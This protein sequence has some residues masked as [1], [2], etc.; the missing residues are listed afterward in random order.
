[1]LMSNIITSH[2]QSLLF[3]LII[4]SSSSTYLLHFGYSH[5]CFCFFSL[6]FLIYFFLATNFVCFYF[7]AANIEF[8]YKAHRFSSL[9]HSICVRC[10]F[11]VGSRYAIGCIIVSAYEDR[12]RRMESRSNHVQ[13]TRY[14]HDKTNQ[15][16]TE[17]DYARVKSVLLGDCLQELNKC[18]AWIAVIEWWKT[19]QWKKKL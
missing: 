6:I 15:I 9:L 18:Q 11:F 3:I 2:S 19:A 17:I 7:S 10:W 1:M 14:T 16:W 13:Q 5:L 4:F 8:N 12:W